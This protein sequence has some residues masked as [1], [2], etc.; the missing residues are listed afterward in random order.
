MIKVIMASRPA[1]WQSMQFGA[2]DGFTSL[3]MTM[4]FQVESTGIV[5]RTK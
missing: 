3:A 1:A 2:L 4:Y 5:I